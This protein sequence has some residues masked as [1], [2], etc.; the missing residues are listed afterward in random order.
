MAARTRSWSIS[1]SSGSTAAGSM[2]I[3]TT[4]WSPVTTALTAPPPA[5]A[6]TDE[7]LELRL[8]AGHLG[9]H[10]LGH[11]GQVA[12]AHRSISCSAVRVSRP[13]RLRRRSP[14]KMR[15]ACATRSSPAG[16]CRRRRARC[17][18]PRSVPPSGAAEDGGDPLL[19]RPTACARPC[20]AGTPGSRESRARRR[21]HAP[22]RAGRRQI[23]PVGRVARHELRRR[24][25]SRGAGPRA[26]RPTGGRRWRQARAG[27]RGAARGWRAPVGARASAGGV[28]AAC[29]GRTPRGG[30]RDGA[31][32]A[33]L[34]PGCR[35]RAGLAGSA[36]LLA[37]A[38]TVA[39]VGGRLG[40]RGARHARLSAARRPPPSRH[41][42]SCQR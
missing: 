4:S 9:L 11:L 37:A 15:R 16:R 25:A 21:R 7:R 19:E 31:R 32:R 35:L 28:G 18:S 8:D 33:R 34:R 14:S 2:V 38:R 20:R 12:H 23:G 1:T 27:V 22:R 40:R 10:L 39:G 6:S 30:R 17:W 13:R 42:S 36:A 26:G 41:S 24:A 5:L 3:E 29:S